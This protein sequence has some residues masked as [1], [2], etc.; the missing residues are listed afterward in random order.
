MAKIIVTA[1]ITTWRQSKLG[2]GK[3]INETNMAYILESDRGNCWNH[4]HNAETRWR[5]AHLSSQPYHRNCCKDNQTTIAPHMDASTNT[6]V[7]IC[8]SATCVIY[9]LIEVKWTITCVHY[10]FSIFYDLFRQ[11]TN[12]WFSF[13]NCE[14]DLNFA[15]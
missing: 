2:R 4:W 1:T 6:I 9:Q 13:Y 12:S 3:T 10:Y 8:E 11:G 14:S 15:N 7:S 5:R